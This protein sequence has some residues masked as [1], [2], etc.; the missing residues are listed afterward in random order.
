MFGEF[1]HLVPLLR[2]CRHA[3]VLDCSFVGEFCLC[4]WIIPQYLWTSDWTMG[5]PCSLHCGVARRCDLG[6]FGDSMDRIGDYLMQG[7]VVD[8]DL[9]RFGGH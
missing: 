5:L 2:R 8:L 7:L 6:Q 1:W 4:G 9:P 3:V